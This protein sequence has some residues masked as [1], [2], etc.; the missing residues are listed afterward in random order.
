MPKKNLYWISYTHELGEWKAFLLES[1]TSQIKT[2]C[3]R[4]HYIAGFSA[5][6]VVF[7]LWVKRVGVY[8]L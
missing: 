6:S 2:N 3:E 8:T 5:F 1:Y 7:A 4:V